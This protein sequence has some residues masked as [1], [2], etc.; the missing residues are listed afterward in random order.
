MEWAVAG[1]LTCW[2]A[3]RLA[4][5]DRLRFAEAWAV[6]LL[7]FTP[8][9]TAGAWASALLLRGAGPAAATAAA[10]AA[11]TAAVGPRAVP[12]RQ[13][14]AAGPVLR[15]LT[16]NLLVGRAAAEMVVELVRRKHAD[17]LFVQELTDEAESGLQ[18]A[19]LGDLLPHRAAQPVPRGTR[20]SIYARYPLRAEPL[21]APP[22]AA[23]CTARLDLPS[24]Q[25]V[26]LAC[27]H[28]E[29]P[30]PPWSPDAAARWRSQLSTL[31]A[32]GDIPRILAGDFNATFDHA[33]F[34]R[35]LR[36]GYL[37]AAS[38]VGNGLSLTWGPRPG[39]RPTLLAID[40][41]L[42]DRRCAVVTTST[43]WLTGSDHRALYAELRLPAPHS[44]R[45]QASPRPQQ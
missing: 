36:R 22:S 12:C 28:A 35:L 9:V 14:P 43:Y 13:A 39:R 25:S 18:Q 19:G 29:S 5:A 2:A 26:Q 34:R 23:R 20:G 3:A 30:K 17:V 31:P 38:Q 40:H 10:G 27:I 8:Q 1:A 32:P 16:A 24:G 33:Q 41:V 21:T 44:R 42:I 11:L 45:D 15:V 7:S 4:G 6:P 37:D